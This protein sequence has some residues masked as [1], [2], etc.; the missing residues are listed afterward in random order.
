MV[1]R[2]MRREYERELGH[3]E[4]IKFYIGKSF[5]ISNLNGDGGWKVKCVREK[6]TE[7]TLNE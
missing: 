6:W 7:R 4:N 3:W 2:E 1:R 5:L